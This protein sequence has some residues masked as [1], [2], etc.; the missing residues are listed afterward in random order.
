MIRFLFAII[1][2]LIAET[3]MAKAKIVVLGDSI[4]SGYGLEVGQGWVS[5]LQAKLLAE[6]DCCVIAN[7]SIGGDT[8]AGGL[9]RLD[10]LLTK[11]KPNILIVELGGNDG[12]RGLP[13]TVLKQNLAEII[14]RA[15]QAGAKVFLLSM[16][17]PPNYGKRYVDMFYKVYPQLAKE[18][19]VTSIPFILEDV[20]L[21]KDLMQADGLHPNAKAQPIIADKVWQ[22]LRPLLK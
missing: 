20:A 13:T 10:P 21:V 7:E 19:G 16:R 6:H 1:V 2:L 4:S 17:I 8:S 15:R 14:Q 3:T 9:A 11:H 18:L 12:L 5:L 22:H